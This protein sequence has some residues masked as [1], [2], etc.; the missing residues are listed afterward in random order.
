MFSAGTITLFM[1]YFPVIRYNNI[2]RFFVI[3]F[4]YLCC[5]CYGVVQKYFV[6]WTVAIP[7]YSLFYL[8]HIYCSETNKKYS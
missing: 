4:L 8:V 5:L 7:F 6:L 3:F 1:N 2:Y